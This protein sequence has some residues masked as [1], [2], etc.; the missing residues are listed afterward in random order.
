MFDGLSADGIYE[1]TLIMHDNLDRRYAAIF[2]LYP[3]RLAKEGRYWDNCR[4]CVRRDLKIQAVN[5]RQEHEVEGE[6]RRHD[7][8]LTAHHHQEAVA[9]A[10]YP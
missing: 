4:D 1:S 3:Q 6:L 10:T 7:K 9:S 5:L 8:M 2:E